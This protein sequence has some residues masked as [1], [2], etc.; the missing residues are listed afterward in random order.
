MTDEPLD[1]GRR[2]FLLGR[3]SRN[4]PQPAPE[5]HVTSLI[6]HAFPDAA[7][8]VV[9]AL[10]ALAGIEVHAQ[11]PNGKIIITL[12]TSEDWEIVARLNAIHDI[13]GVL[14]AVLVFHHVE[15]T[16]QPG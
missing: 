10:V 15:T 7:E 3:S 16:A 13:P 14:S 9:S 2:S 6:V 11:H 4:R 8:S 5:A 1:P 12:E